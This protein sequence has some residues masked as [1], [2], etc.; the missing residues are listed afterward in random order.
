MKKILLILFLSFVFKL[1]GQEVK[2]NFI[3]ADNNTYAKLVQRYNSKEVAPFWINNGEMFIYCIKNE[4]N[5]E[6]F[7]VDIHK[8]QKKKLDIKINKIDDSNYDFLFESKQYSYDSRFNQIKLKEAES[9][10]PN[11]E[12]ISPD[13]K[14][15]VFEKNHNLFINRKGNIS[16]ITYDG[17][18]FHDYKEND[19]YFTN[20]LNREDTSIHTSNISWSPNSDFFIAFRTD[21]R[22]LKDNW[23]INSITEPRTSLTTYKQRNPGDP[24][25]KD[26]IWVYNIVNNEFFQADLKRWEGE[27]YWFLG[28]NNNG[29]NCFIQ[30]IN[31]H[32][33][34][35]DIIAINKQ[36]ESTIIIEERPNANIFPKEFRELDEDEYLWFSRRDG[37]GHLYIYDN[38]IGE[39][40]QITK[41]E[42]SVEQVVSVKDDIIYFLAKG[43]EEGINPYYSLFYSV[44]IKT[45]E[46]K[47]LSPENA[48]HKILI[49]PDNKYFIDIY[50]RIDQPHKSELRDTNGNLILSLEEANISELEQNKWISPKVFTVKAADSITNLWGV[51]WKPFDFDPNKTYPIISFVYPG[52]Q[53]NFVPTG[54]HQQ[55]NNMHLAQYGFIVVMCGTRGSSYQRTVEFSE[56]FRMGL[57]D[58][59]LVDN[60]YMIEQLAK[61]HSFININKVGIWGGSSGGFM[62]ASAMLKYPEFYKVGVSRA[63]QHDPNVFHAWWTDVFNNKINSEIDYPIYTNNSLAHNLQGKLFIIHGEVD[64]NVHPS[65]SARLVNEL[66]KAG[67]DFDYLVVPGGDH[68]WSHNR[69]YVQKRIWLYFVENLMNVKN[70]KTNIFTN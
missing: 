17:E 43:K 35:C 9:Y 29:N 4:K 39:I 56:Y 37:W 30:R 57:R 18:V 41:G 55:L 21:A 14:Y 64:T 67:K 49:S 15:S 25:S 16:Q 61:K 60:K 66:M 33:T 5:I 42:F 53:H 20:E 6:L 34:E 7:Q 28:W 50:S 68:G 11:S 58:Y 38:G 36:G 12:R 31:K 48:G 1:F 10:K 27:N 32:Q 2:P 62:A 59:P 65:N 47:L 45:K 26:E 69:E 40:N 24:K 23:V 70:L 19:Y 63:G 52:P 46:I 13:N 54:F 44:N 22:M 8:K 51:M 3:L